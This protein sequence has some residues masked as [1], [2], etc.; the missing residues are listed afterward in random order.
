MIHA[1]AIIPLFLPLVYELIQDR[2][3]ESKRD[4][5]QDWGARLMLVTI[6]AMGNMWILREH[7]NYEG[8]NFMRGLYSAMFLSFA[9][10]LMLF[11]YLIV[12]IL[13]KNGVIRPDAK[14]FSYLG[15]T[16]NYPKLWVKIGPW[17]RF[18]IRLLTLITA[19]IIYLV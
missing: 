7:V 6:G 1:L 5:R 17:G 2:N 12:I 13:K 16:A 18:S 8:W 3:G 4:K 11:D 9:I 19:I 14:P 10:H 15:K